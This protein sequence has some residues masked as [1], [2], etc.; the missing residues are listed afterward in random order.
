M[1]TETKVT[2]A[3]DAPAPAKPVT[4]ITVHPRAQEALKL[5]EHE[6]ALYRRELYRLLAEN[7]A[8]RHALVKGDDLTI[9]DTSGDAIQAGHLRF[10]LEPFLVQKIDARDVEMF[11]L[12]DE[13]KASQCQS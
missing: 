3:N 4:P 1:T 10:G 7:E 6:Y 5:L 8:G 9:W 11:R 12:L 13:W 2:P